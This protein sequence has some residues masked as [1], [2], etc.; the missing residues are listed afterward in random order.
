MNTARSPSGRSSTWKPRVASRSKRAGTTRAAARNGGRSLRLLSF[1][2]HAG[3]ST[4]RYH[5]YLTHSWRQ[6]LPHAQRVDNLDVIS[7]LVS[8][9]DMAAL[10]EVDTGSLRSGYLNQSR[11]IATHA[12]MPYWTH[13]SNRKLGKMSLTGNGFMA[14]F[15]PTTVEEHR[16]PG[17]IPGRGSLIMRFGQ[18]SALVVAV[19]HLALGRRARDLQLKYLVRHLDDAR[20]L[21]VLGD[22]NTDVSSAQMELFCGRL[23]LRAATSGLLSLPVLAAAARD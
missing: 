21:I 1:N 6:V 5:H 19:V 17:V 11:Y 4:D 10:Q 16:L 22:L 20:N 13:Q 12:G 23:G 3:T 7:E 15:E 18:D 9:Y 14:R 2:I 8:Q